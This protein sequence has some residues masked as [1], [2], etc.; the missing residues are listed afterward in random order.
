MDKM[1]THMV[2]VDGDEVGPAAP[3]LGVAVGDLVREHG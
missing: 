2:E 3:R 1:A